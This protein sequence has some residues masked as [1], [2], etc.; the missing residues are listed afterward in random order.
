VQIDASALDSDE[1]AS[2]LFRH[3]RAAGLDDESRDW[4]RANGPRIVRH[5]H[6]TPERIRRL[7]A[8]GRFHGDPEP[9]LER[10]LTAPTE[11][12]ATSLGALEREH[13]DLLIALLDV[14]PGPASERDLAASLRRHHAGGLTRAPAELVEHLADHFVQVLA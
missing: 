13:R 9:I 3:A 1:K 2:I 4:L 6:F 14:P 5:R 12:M 10:E 7:I 11:A 8:R